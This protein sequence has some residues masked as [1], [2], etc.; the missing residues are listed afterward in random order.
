MNQC[1]YGFVCLLELCLHVMA[2]RMLAF[3]LPAWGPE[4][5][6]VLPRWSVAE[7]QGAKGANCVQGL[8]DLSPLAQSHS[9]GQRK[10][11]NRKHV[12]TFEC[13]SSTCMW[14]SIRN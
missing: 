11:R 6:G 12:L 10:H 13:L 4:C 14:L 7:E 9:A 3:V 5:K 2:R 1:V 8:P